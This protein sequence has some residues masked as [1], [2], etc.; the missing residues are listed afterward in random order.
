M[1]LVLPVWLPSATCDPAGK[2][3]AMLIV[4]T[5]GVFLFLVAFGVAQARR[6]RLLRPHRAICSSAKSR[7]SAQRRLA[8]PLIALILAVPLFVP[9]AMSEA[10]IVP[11]VGL[12]TAGQYSALAGSTITNTG[13]TLLEGSL[14]LSEGTDVTGFTFSTTPGPGVVEGDVN[15][16]NPAAVQAKS[17]LT[18]A[19]GN[20]AGRPL[21]AE[22]A[23]DLVGLTLVGG[24]Y[25]V[26]GK[27]AMGLTGTLTLDGA[28]NPN[29]VFIFQTNSTL[30]TGSSANVVLINGAQACNVFWQVGSS[31]TIGSGSSFVGTVM[32]EASITVASGAN[33]E[34]RVLAQSGAV[35]FDNNRISVPACDM[36]VAEDTTTTTEAAATTTT[37]EAAPTT[38]EAAPTTTVA[39]GDDEGE[40]PDTGA[41]SVVM[42][43][44]GGIGLL[45][46]GSAVIASAARRRAETI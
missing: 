4:A 21:N 9:V 24:V 37:T 45:L 46:V 13:P 5:V 35:T 6:A 18:V 30:I 27:G 17:D 10:A 2:E 33:V 44:L 19:Y 39:S 15:I 42:Y 8:A 25:A 34:G 26:S 41:G 36:S 38:T 12:G 11:T 1:I 40:L 3:A 23:A 14:G 20:A 32:A 29:S 28:N 43:L 7:R 16:A 31:A 22:V